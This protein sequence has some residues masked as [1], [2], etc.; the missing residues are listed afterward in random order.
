MKGSADL[1]AAL[2]TPPGIGAVAMV[3]L[4]GPGLLEALDKILV[5][6]ADL[7][8]HPREMCLARI[9][10]P[11]GDRIVDEVLAVYFPEP[12]SFTGEDCAEIQ[13][14]A[15]PAVP[16]LVLEAVLKAG[17]RLAGPGE[18]TQRA[19]LNGR[20]SLDQAEA[21][22]ELVAAQS[23]SEAVLAAR[24]L[25]GALRDCLDPITARLT[26]LMAKLTAVLDFEESWEDEDR[27]GMAQELD[28]LLEEVRHL[29]SL[30]KNGRLF[31]EGLRLVLAGPPNS[32]KSSL[33]N[34]LLGLD[35]ALVS[36]RPGTTRDYLEAAVS[37]SGIRVELVDTAGLWADSLDEIDRLGQ[38]RTRQQM[39]GSDL[40]VWLM[41]LTA[42]QPV[43]PP[44]TGAPLLI[45]W[46]KSDLASPEELARAGGRLTVSS[47]SAAG[48]AGFKEEC[49]KM[50]GLKSQETP[51]LVPNLR[52]QQALEKTLVSAEAAA[53]AL[54]EGLPPDIVN[55]ELQEA[56]SH[57]GL[58]T[59]RVMT[60]DLLQEVFSRF[61]IGK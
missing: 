18:F 43:P 47:K 44:E 61:C 50:L 12:R 56:L 41:D 16:R 48:L 15:G 58:I 3:R 49:L 14:H 38:E 52:H 33:F 51:D 60:E 22:A 28:R 36:P 21:V 35:R 39:E 55:L 34:A 23:Q 6:R 53:S 30:R 17:A 45:V 2:A 54:A 19:F 4:S 42:R 27:A 37:W 7:R 32:G 57:L 1:I 13:G 5:T 8:R 31:R 46:T 20:L 25:S 40:I 26:S 29:I 10:G 11:E 59:G 9:K 24:Q